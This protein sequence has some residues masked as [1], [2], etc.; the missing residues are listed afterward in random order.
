MF[1]SWESRYSRCLSLLLLPVTQYYTLDNIAGL[2]QDDSV[3]SLKCY[4]F[5]VG[6]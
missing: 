3:F 1:G 6:E 5:K 2:I 4:H